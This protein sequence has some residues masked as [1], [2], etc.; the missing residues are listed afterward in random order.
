MSLGG[1]GGGGGIGGGG[2]GGGGLAGG[3]S[4]SAAAPGG[5][6]PFAGIPS[7]LQAGVDALL[8]GE[9]DHGEP[10]ASFSYAS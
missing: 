3:G 6:L 1:F 10:D 5:G 8:A 7:E 4:R 9:P 2:L